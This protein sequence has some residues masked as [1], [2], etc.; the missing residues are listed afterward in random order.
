MP[1]DDKA[2]GEQV[3]SQ[4]DDDH[5][6]TFY[7]YVM[8]AGT[9]NIHFGI[10]RSE[11]RRPLYPKHLLPGELALDAIL[12]RDRC[13]APAT[14]LSLLSRSAA[15]A[16]VPASLLL[17]PPPPLPSCSCAANSLLST[18]VKHLS[19]DPLGPLPRN[20]LNNGCC[21]THRPARF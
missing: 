4:Y 21:V 20:T 8:G 13:L 3:I 15:A 12:A 18:D 9:Q 10:F 11:V 14:D 5:A 7:R 1:K 16:V 17:L 19:T 6:R 2:I